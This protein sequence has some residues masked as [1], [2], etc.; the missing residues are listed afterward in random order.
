MKADV[1]E[2]EEISASG[3]RFLRGNKFHDRKSC[4][5]RDSV[6]HKCSTKEYF[7]NV[8]KARTYISAALTP[9]CL[10]FASCEMHYF[11][12]SFPSSLASSII[13]DMKMKDRTFRTYI[14]CR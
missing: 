4:P 5:A 3:N 6:C 8:C 11:T 2:I 13:I 10:H 14:K 12:P 1:E 7:A 9:P